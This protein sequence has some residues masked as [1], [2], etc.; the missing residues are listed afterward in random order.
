MITF[1]YKNR[2]N[3][4]LRA[5]V[6]LGI[7]IVMVSAPGNA[8]RLVVQV[9][10]AF[11]IA[12]GL[13]SLVFGLLHKKEGGL[14]LL[15]FNSIVDIA[16]GALLFA[17]PE[18]VAGF[19][20]VLIGVALLLLGILQLVALAGAV[21]LL[22][23]GFAAYIMPVVITLIGGFLLFNPF[24]S[25]EVMCIIAGCAL[26]IYG[27]SELLSTWRMKKAMQE[28]EI[29]HAPDAGTPKEDSVTDV[30]EIKDVDYEKVDDSSGYSK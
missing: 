19:I 1:G 7:G 12:S 20:I 17:F 5:V 13:V 14:S 16:I 30:A 25:T 29:R 6:A 28:Y 3:G 4:I 27:A 22:G 24:E 11:F 9:I 15:L 21:P 18:F 23:L 10:A 2:F 26:I 8:L